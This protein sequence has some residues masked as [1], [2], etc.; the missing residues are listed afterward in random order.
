M[1]L[2][3]TINKLVADFNGELYLTK[4]ETAR[5]LRVSVA[6]VD[7]YRSMGLIKATKR[8]QKVYFSV[9]VIAKVLRDGIDATGMTAHLEN[10]QRVGAN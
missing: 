10:G 3:E 4:K 7:N 9:D 6:S 2:K 5:A 1:S 8:G